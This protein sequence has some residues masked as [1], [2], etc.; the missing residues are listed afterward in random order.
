MKMTESSMSRV[1]DGAF[2]F[3]SGDQSQRSYGKE[4]GWREKRIC[5]KAFLKIMEI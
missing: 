2:Y 3:P 4:V 1:K 5:M